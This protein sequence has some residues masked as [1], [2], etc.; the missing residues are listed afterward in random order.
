MKRDMRDIYAIRLKYEIASS[1]YAVD[2][3]SGITGENTPP[4][5][6]PGA[7]NLKLWNFTTCSDSIVNQWSLVGASATCEP[8]KGLNLQANAEG[9]QLLGPDLPIDLRA[10]QAW[11]VR[12]RASVAY[13]AASESGSKGTSQWFWRYTDNET[14][15]S[16]KGKIMPINRDGKPHVYWTYL[17]I[18]EANDAIAQ[19]RF[20]PM[21]SAEQATIEWIA[22]DLVR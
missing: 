10:E 13:P 5:D 18:E 20:D 11:Y 9:A 22:V 1:K 2:Y 3:L 4:T 19:L 16:T 8:G 17:T 15:D 21:R 12:I 6:S 14:W 7:V